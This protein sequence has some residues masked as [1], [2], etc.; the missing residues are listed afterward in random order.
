MCYNKESSL[1]IF[2]FVLVV[3]IKLIRGGDVFRGVALLAYGSIQLAEYFIWLSMYYKY[4]FGNYMSSIF[5]ALILSIQPLVL[6]VTYYLIDTGRLEDKNQ[7]SR[8]QEL[9]NVNFVLIGVYTCLMIGGLMYNVST[10][11]MEKLSSSVDTGGSCRLLWNVLH[12][13]YINIIATIL[14]IITTL[15]ILYDTEEWSIMIIYC[16]TFVFA[17]IYS[18]AFAYST[19]SIVGTMWCFVAIVLLVFFI[20]FDE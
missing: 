17:V 13:N 11:S 16:S 2:L 14:Y 18:Y 3:S 5:L 1:L 20:I 19:K 7:Y 10:Y 9:E 8:N 4:K 12:N 6:A 15:I